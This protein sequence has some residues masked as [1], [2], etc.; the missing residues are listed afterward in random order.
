M[1]EFLDIFDRV[2]DPAIGAGW[3]EQTASESQLLNNA[4]RIGGAVDFGDSIAYRQASEDFK[5]GYVEVDF[6]VTSAAAV[7][8]IH[9]RYNPAGTTSYLCYATSTALVV[10]R[11]TGVAAATILDSVPFVLDATEEYTLKFECYGNTKRA[12]ISFKNTGAPIA[13]AEDTADTTHLTAGSV[14]VS[15]STN[16]FVDYSRFYHSGAVDKSITCGPLHDG[17]AL[18]ASDTGI[19]AYVHDFIS[20]ELVTTV[21]S[22]TTDVSGNLDAIDNDSVDNKR[23]AVLLERSNGDIGY[24]RRSDVT[25]PT[26]HVAG[27][28]IQSGRYT[29]VKYD[30]LGIPGN[31]V[32]STGT[33]G[34]GYMYPALNLPLEDTNEFQ[35]RITS[36]PAVTGGTGVIQSI[37]IY[38]DSSFE[39]ETD[40]YAEVSWTY[41]LYLDN[42]LEESGL[43]ATV[44]VGTPGGLTSDANIVFSTTSDLSTRSLLVSDSSVAFST[45]ADLTV[46]NLLSSDANITCSTDSDLSIGITFSSDG[47]VVFTSTMGTSDAETFQ[48][49]IDSLDNGGKS[50][51]DKLIRFL[52]SRGYSGSVTDMMYEYLKTVSSKTSHSE[53]WNDWRDRG[54]Y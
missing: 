8:Q 50:T 27:S 37:A 14:G 34:A 52:N 53:R 20:G 48:Q 36:A 24:I 29:A 25:W 17:T 47:S 45:S 16:G 10:A 2:D 11:M 3:L 1:A 19:T 15:N 7:P 28:D 4:L 22:L 12:T 5:D 44:D 51:T 35:A 26:T 49:F 30:G 32:P 31:Q 38:D 21:S 9:M 33:H 41:D 23:Y 43:T 40:A 54:F 46:G 42:V 18:I 13:V 39:I 6:T